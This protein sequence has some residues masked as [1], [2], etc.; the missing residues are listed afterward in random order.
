MNVGARADRVRS[1]PY[2]WLADAQVL[3]SS[4]DTEDARTIGRR[5]RQVRKAL[6]KAQVVIAELAGISGPTLSRIEHGEHAPDSLS[7]I[8]ALANALRIPLSELSRLPVPAPEEHTD[9]PLRRCACRWTRSTG[10]AGWSLPVELLRDRAAQIYQQH[11]ACYT[12]RVRLPREATRIAHQGEPPLPL[13]M[14]QTG[15]PWRPGLLGTGSGGR[16][17]ICDLW[18]TRSPYRT[19]LVMSEC[20]F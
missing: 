9:P 3:W 19:V 20:G 15:P 5:V 4:M 2:R 14:K 1:G 10:R 11:R 6:G 16:I 18:V 12:V 7:Q 17:R 13:S 8:V